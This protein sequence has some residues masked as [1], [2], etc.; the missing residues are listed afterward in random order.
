MLNVEFGLRNAEWKRGVSSQHGKAERKRQEHG[1]TSK[2]LTNTLII[3][4][5][6]IVIARPA[7]RHEKD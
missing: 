3:V 1:K 5:D 7:R 6:K 2:A 4:N